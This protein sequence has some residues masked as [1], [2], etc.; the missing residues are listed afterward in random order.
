LQRV[1]SPVQADTDRDVKDPRALRLSLDDAIRTS[2]RQNL[3]VE[4]ERYSF[5]ETAEDLAGSYGIFDIFTTAQL[6][7]SAS[8]SP[9][10][11]L[12][13]ASSSGRTNA[14]ADA[15]QLLPTGGS[16]S[17]GVE[18]QRFTRSGSGTSISPG[19]TTALTFGL[20]Q[21]L[22]RNFGIDVTSRGI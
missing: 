17:V 20:T 14:N 5:R 9:S 3:G 22:A 10:L 4:L 11:S 12:F 19:Y 21:P 13:D 18:N 2:I 16:Y 15:R 7:T 6:N 1:T 8:D